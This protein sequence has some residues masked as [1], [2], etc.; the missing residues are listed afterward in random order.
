MN[1]NKL[2]IEKFTTRGDCVRMIARH[3]GQQNGRCILK[4]S[5]D[6]NS[7]DITGYIWSWSSFQ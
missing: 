4:R 7:K 1:N 2:I 6:G 5:K 3:Y